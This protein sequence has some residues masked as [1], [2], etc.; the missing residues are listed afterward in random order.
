MPLASSI[1]VCDEGKGSGMFLVAD[2]ISKS[3]SQG[4]S[5]RPEPGT[6]IVSAQ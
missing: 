1:W 2:S 6:S 5:E 4:L 3:T